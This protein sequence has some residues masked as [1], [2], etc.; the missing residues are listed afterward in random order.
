MP[1]ENREVGGHWESTIPVQAP[2]GPVGVVSTS[3]IGLQEVVNLLTG[4]GVGV[5]QVVRVDGHDLSLE[6]GGSAVLAGLLALQADPGT[7]IIVLISKTPVLGAAERVLAEVRD[8]DKPT[9]VCFLGADQRLVWRAGAIPT[10]RLDEAAYR[11]AAWV[12]GWD[13]ALITSRLEDLDEKL[14]IQAGDLSARIGSGR[15]LFQGLFTCGIFCQEARLMLV[16]VIG[17]MPEGTCLDLGG[18]P[19]LQQSYLHGALD[20]SATAVILLDVVSGHDAGPDPAGMLANVLRG[21]RDGALVIAHVCDTTDAPQCLVERESM[22]RDAGV[23]LA[24]SNAVAARLAG[25]IVA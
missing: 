3:P 12:R 23:I 5:S 10:A 9:V 19:S 8:S 24:A 11:A 18:E 1:V 7:E 15:R 20:D 22:L 17:R 14:A 25:M 16:D 21:D 6:A 4:E 2:K 13:Q